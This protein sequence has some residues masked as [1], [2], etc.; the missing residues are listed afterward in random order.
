MSLGFR[1]RRLVFFK[2]NGLL[3]LAPR[4]RLDY[5]FEKPILSLKEPGCLKFSFSTT[6][7]IPTMSH[8]FLIWEWVQPKL[9]PQL[10]VSARENIV[11]RVCP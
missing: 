6:T 1:G 10:V 11:K 9:A 4:I 5:H 3:K 7:T 8:P 2:E